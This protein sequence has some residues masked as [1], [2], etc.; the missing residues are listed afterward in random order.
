[1]RFKELSGLL[2]KR[3]KEIGQPE[4]MEV[5]TVNHETKKRLLHSRQNISHEKTYWRV[6]F[7][8]NPIQTVRELKKNR[9]EM[10]FE[11]CTRN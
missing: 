6:Y 5:E 8:E 9:R 10:T 4:K 1:M 11:W 3:L 7:G 2:L